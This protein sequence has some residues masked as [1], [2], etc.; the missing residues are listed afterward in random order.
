MGVIRYLVQDVDASIRFYEALGFELTDRPGPPFAAVKRG[1]LTLWISG[2]GS[3]AA[4]TLP[5][6]QK[7]GPGGWNRLVLEVEDIEAALGR[8]RTLGMRSRS[9]PRS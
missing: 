6:G 3:S 9:E 8:L 4:R 7:P 1:D 2:P 5:D